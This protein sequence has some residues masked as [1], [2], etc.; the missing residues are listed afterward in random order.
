MAKAT[1]SEVL[2]G[3]APYDALDG[4]AQAVVR[5]GWTERLA[6]QLDGA[7]FTEHLRAN[8]Q[9][10]AEADADG[11]VVMRDPGPSAADA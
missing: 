2:A 9:P 7:D 6:E 8:G 10:W 4:P 1:I 5:A 3:H 11:N